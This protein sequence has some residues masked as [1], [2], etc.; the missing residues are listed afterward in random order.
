MS[1]K[2]ILDEVLHEIEGGLAQIEFAFH[3]KTSSP[4][5][6]KEMERLF[7]RAIQRIRHLKSRLK[8]ISLP[9]AENEKAN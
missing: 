7:V 6:T 5:E 2:E 8:E 4:S 1:T 3:A 9:G